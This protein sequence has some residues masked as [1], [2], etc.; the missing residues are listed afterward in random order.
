[1]SWKAQ[2]LGEV[3]QQRASN[4][5]ALVTQDSRFTYGQL[6]EQA[7]AAAGGMQALGLK[8]GDPV[9][10]LM[11][12][13]EKWLA[14]FYGAALIGAVTVPVNTR[15][16]AAEI[17][18]CLKQA[19]CKALFYVECFLNIDFGAMVRAIGFANAVDV[20]CSLPSGIFSQ[21][22]V[23]PED[24]LLIQ[25]TSGTT[26]YPKGAMLTH[27]NML[28]DAWAAGT[29]IGIR[30]EDRYFN[31]RPFFHVAGST[32]SA[33][34]ALVSGACLVTLPTFEAGAALELM[35]RE[36]CTL[37]SG[38]DTLM[39]MLMGHADFP[40]RKLALRGGWA[41]AG[42][43]TMRAIIDVLGAK[44]ICAAYG[45]SEA[46]PNVVMS[47]WRDAE[48]LRIAGLA[49]PHEGVEV[50]IKEGEIQVRGWNVM[51][52]YCNNPEANAKVFT[53]DGWLRTGDLGELTADGRLRMIGRLKDVF[54]VG[55][56][57]VAPAEVE[58]VL[59][60][61]PAVETA[62]VVGVPDPR[63][64]EVACAYVTLKAGRRISECELT[65][66]C[67]SRMANFRVPRYVR[68]VED[69]EA[70]G[71]TASG[72]VQKAKLREHALREFKLNANPSVDPTI[73]R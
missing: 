44:H 46:S 32:L 61:H 40:K 39:Q 6:L 3:L 62:Q 13:D 9:G 20:S 60:A 67:K 30:A 68:I 27:D 8:R 4:T 14:L 33:L 28:R 18:F 31:C 22:P 56:E 29:R 19:Q 7:K 66:W 48:E 36:R 51:R 64:G 41:A 38:N 72:K 52:G 35:E 73:S 69:F 34:M 10:I 49:R 16:K 24:L 47:D 58:E 65:A 55:G 45:L 23:R 70:I 12:N 43:Q 5:E 1:M 11:G 15:F 53:E 54:R 25:F 2:T 17:D 71:M 42:P 57:N 63:L 26:A 59:L 21:V 50:R 37:L